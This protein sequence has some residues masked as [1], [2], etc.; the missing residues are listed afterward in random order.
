[1][2]RHDAFLPL[3]TGA[4]IAGVLGV[5]LVC[6]ARADEVLERV[7]V[8][9]VAYR[10]ERGI[11]ETAAT[12]SAISRDDV[13]HS[14][15]SN[16][17]D[18]LRYEPGVTVEGSA[19]RFGLGDIAIRG[20]GGNRVLMQVD[21]IRLPDSYRVGR[22]SSASR[23]QFDLALLKRIEILRGPGSALYGSD[24]L[25]GVVAL[26]T[27][28]PA[29]FLT[30]PSNI[31]GEARGGYA[32]VSDRWT[33]SAVLAGEQSSWQALL[34]YQRSSGHETGNQGTVDI[35]G[36]TRTAPD[37]QSTT[38]E[39]LLGK[40]VWDGRA[41]WRLG[42]ER[43]TQQV[44][45]GVL[46]LN[47]Q[48]IRT[49]SLT[50]DDASQRSRA[51]I[52]ADAMR[53]GAFSRLRGLV[54]TQ[55][56]LTLND[57]E[58][59]RAS[60]TPVCLSAPGLTSCLRDVRFRFEQKEVGANLLAE[61]DWYGNWLAGIEVA[62]T[63]YDESRN[64][65]QTNLNTGEVVNVVG[66]EPMP[67]R[68]FPRTTSDRIGAF[69][70]DELRLADGRLDLVPGLRFDAFRTR[71]NSDPVFASANP[72]RPVVNSSDTALSPKLGVLYR[73][74]PTL[75]VTAQ[76][77]TGFRAPPAAD[78]NLGLSNLPAGYAV[79][80]NPDLR[81]ERSRG[82]EIGVR[83]R[84]RR[85]DFTA[86]AFIADYE[87]LIVS[88]AAL[89]CPGDPSCVAGAAG[90][91][92][93]Q[94]I[95]HARIHGIEVDARYRFTGAWSVRGSFSSAYGTD[96]DR[97]RPLNTIDPPRAVIGLLYEQANASAAVHVTYTRKKQRIDAS[98]G[99]LF[100]P[101]SSTVVDLNLSWAIGEQ[102]RLTVGVFN[103]FD[104]T[105]WL[106]SEVRGVI[107]PGA[108]ID[109]YTQPGRNASLLL[110]ARF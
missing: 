100:A 59:R 6:A 87:D 46:S 28:D 67:T 104:S 35:V 106:W 22:F 78:L 80:P 52:D 102:L 81:A 51:S 37:P 18:V 36:R 74:T 105:Y 31:G 34:G 48:S 50:G 15:A 41:R 91:F 27:V 95:A 4:T 69:V 88:R 58:D 32:S 20:I 8:V 29:D 71:A 23:N 94:N 10:V 49:V 44:R 70:Q 86:T 40:L 26:S 24:A 110:R 72:G 77:A 101:P 84:Q 12:V 3:R 92:Q 2:P 85:L 98:A 47:P 65:T 30:G 55:R 109:R 38:N 96:T 99:E 43:N 107:S 19:G 5:L 97:D 39:S 68:D 42:F 93:S 60:T 79:V 75:N 76:L 33:G 89:P 7:E 11:D 103:V 14:A 57:T 82:A 83:G 54:Y 62:R 64:G 13:E 63:R 16:L 17:R 108:T 9:G 56:A 61:A 1:V 90:T 53:V 25:G 45:T 73:A 66:G 21:G